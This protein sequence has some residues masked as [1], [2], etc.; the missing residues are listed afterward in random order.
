MYCA[1]GMLGSPPTEARNPIATSRS[2][3]NSESSPRWEHSASICCCMGP[4]RGTWNNN[5]S[6]ILMLISSSTGCLM[7]HCQFTAIILMCR[8]ATR[9]FYTWFFLAWIWN[10]CKCESPSSDIIWSDNKSSLAMVKGS[11]LIIAIQ[12]H[13]CW[14]FL[15]SLVK[16][17]TLVVSCCSMEDYKKT[18]TISI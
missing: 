17:A 8:I 4:S 1:K 11:M 7:R 14:I 3:S 13:T 6:F 16:V 9:G 15:E 18:E 2:A 5:F 12:V 10:G